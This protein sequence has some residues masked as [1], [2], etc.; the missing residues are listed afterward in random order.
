MAL[1]SKR[2]EWH[3]LRYA[4]FIHS[5]DAVQSAEK[6]KEN[7]STPAGTW[8][9]FSWSDA[10]PLMLSIQDSSQLL[11]TRG[12]LI[13][14]SHFLFDAEHYIKGAFKGDCVLFIQKIKNECR[15]FRV[16][17]MQGPFPS[18]LKACADCIATLQA[19]FHIQEEGAGT[20]QNPAENRMTLEGEVSMGTVAKV[21][22]GNTTLDL[23]LAYHHHQSSWQ[24]EQ[25][26]GALRLCLADP[27][28]PAFVEAVEDELKK[29]NREK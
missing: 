4:R 8:K 20:S 22:L 28:F 21:V 13:L 15:K 17:F 11:I 12:K 2:N 10:E 18:T 1:N 24:P 7:A 9:H 23:P 25:V 6:D 19:F 27:T 3:L 29:L 14:E 5:N 26:A 16:K